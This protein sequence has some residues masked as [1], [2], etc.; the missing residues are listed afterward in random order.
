MLTDALIKP[1]STSSFCLMMSCSLLAGVVWIGWIV[2]ITKFRELPGTKRASGVAAE[3]P[4]PPP[5]FCG[6]K[7]CS[8]ITN[9]ETRPPTNYPTRKT[10]VLISHKQNKRDAPA[11][12]WQKIKQTSKW[13]LPAF[14]LRALFI[15]FTSGG[16]TLHNTSASKKQ[17]SY[18]VFP[19]YFFYLVMP[20]KTKHKVKVCRLMKSSV[21]LQGLICPLFFF[22]FFL[23]L[24][25]K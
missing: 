1:S 23:R 10:S 16:W 17:A 18:S 7:P 4:S 12:R 11:K 3:M 24:V 20:I 14:I 22:C 8:F 25:R 6:C 15:F 13:V 19:P 5:H 2:P 21:E 9:F